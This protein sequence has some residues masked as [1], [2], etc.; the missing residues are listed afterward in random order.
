MPDAC[1]VPCGRQAHWADFTTVALQPGDLLHFVG[2]EPQIG[3]TQLEAR[4]SYLVK[5][6]ITA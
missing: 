2:V 5:D 3:G 4:F 6:G 1:S